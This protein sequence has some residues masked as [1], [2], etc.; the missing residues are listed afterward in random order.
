M[1]SSVIQHAKYPASQFYLAFLKKNKLSFQIL[2]RASSWKLPLFLIFGRVVISWKM[3]TQ[4]LTLVAKM[5]GKYHVFISF[6]KPTGPWVHLYEYLIFGM[7]ITIVEQNGRILSLYLQKPLVQSLVP[8]LSCP[9]HKFNGFESC[10]LAN[11]HPEIR[12]SSGFR[13][14]VLRSW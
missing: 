7:K 13:R 5:S 4:Q 2:L 12:S 10:T 11:L 3:P 9:N 6:T 14:K 8:S 1:L